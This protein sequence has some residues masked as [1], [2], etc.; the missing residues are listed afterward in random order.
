[1]ADHE[2]FNRE[3]LKKYHLCNCECNCSNREH[4]TSEAIDEIYSINKATAGS[5]HNQWVQ[6]FG[7]V[8]PAGLHQ[9]RYVPTVD[10]LTAVGRH[11]PP[12]LLHNLSR[13]Y[14]GRA[15]KDLSP[16]AHTELEQILQRAVIF[17]NE[18][19][20]IGARP[21]LQTLVAGD[22]IRTGNGGHHSG[23]LSPVE[24][25]ICNSVNESLAD[26][27]RVL[28]SQGR[29]ELTKAAGQVSALAAC[30]GRVRL[31]VT[32]DKMVDEGD[33]LNMAK[34]V[35]NDLE[36]G[37]ESPWDSQWDDFFDRN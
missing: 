9:A 33:S 31:E 32:R 26:A 25:V 5:T 13:R 7:I 17:I 18:V 2:I 1:M 15:W 22:P 8:H 10:Q 29:V 3:H 12:E 16:A 24:S 14:Y 28:D 34:H 6:I 37:E 4:L 19:G 36:W 23:P 11:P 27:S 21:A 20:R 35:Q 30:A